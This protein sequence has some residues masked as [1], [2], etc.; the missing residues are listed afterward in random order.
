MSALITQDPCYACDD[1]WSVPGEPPY[2]A[3]RQSPSGEHECRRTFTV[4][5]LTERALAV[6]ALIAREPDR[7]LR[8]E[9]AVE[10]CDAYA[11]VLYELGA[12]LDDQAFYA[13]CGVPKGCVRCEQRKPG[14]GW[15]I[16]C[17]DCAEAVAA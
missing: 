1:N 8:A 17:E 10:V 14:D 9:E 2:W 4:R 16:T 15:R 6:A 3:C 13:A 5:S 12:K 11:N 7:R